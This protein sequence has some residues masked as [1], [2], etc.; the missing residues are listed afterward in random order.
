MVFGI[1]SSVPR[2][3]GKRLGKT[4]EHLGIYEL[5]S[6]E[7]LGQSLVN[8]AGKGSRNNGGN[9]QTKQ[10]G[11]KKKESESED[12]IS[13]TDRSNQFN[14]SASEE[15]DNCMNELEESI[16]NNKDEI[17]YIN[18]N[19]SVV[20]KLLISVLP[21]TSVHQIKDQ[22]KDIASS[23]HQWAH[24]F[25]YQRLGG[26]TNAEQGKNDIVNNSTNATSTATAP[27]TVTGTN[28]AAVAATVPNVSNQE[29]LNNL[30]LKNL[31]DM[32][33]KKNIVITGMD[34]DYDDVLLVRNMLGV[35]GC[36]FLYHDINRRPTRL[37][38]RKNNRNR[39]LKVEM[40]NEE[41][42]EKIMECKKYLRNPNENFY[43][44]YINR[45]LRKEEREK[46]IEQRKARN[47]R[48]FGDSA[49]GAGLS[50]GITGGSGGTPVQRTTPSS[51]LVETVTPENESGI[52]QTSITE[53]SIGEIEVEDGSVIPA[54]GIS[55]E[56]TDGQVGD[57]SDTIGGTGDSSDRGGGI[58]HGP[59]LGS[60]SISN[61]VS[62]D[63]SLG[64]GDGIAGTLQ[65]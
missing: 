54:G 17:K 37:G 5:G 51:G 20:L 30:I 23:D 8:S 44:I 46:E 57:R 39:P 38:M 45:D 29:D 18:E 62:T 42:V 63:N 61:Q 65:T 1:S 47:R 24:D 33:R 3:R 27:Q 36:G 26:K 2:G 19:A 35:M 41:A 40:N 7:G 31:D 15:V 14:L 50:I 49:A 43:S 64:N 52:D 25:I 58:P 9:V 48:I 60:T 34:E 21:M 6:V 32:N 59:N 53:E 16:E 11:V 13:L 10:R 22:I 55:T 4:P 12:N 28:Y 56:I